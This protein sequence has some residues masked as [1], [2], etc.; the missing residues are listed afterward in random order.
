MGFWVLLRLPFWEGKEPREGKEPKEVKE[1]KESKEAQE[2]KEAN[3]A[4]EAKEAKDAR[5]RRRGE[6]E[7]EREAGQNM[8]GKDRTLCDA[9][10]FGL[11]LDCYS[12]NIIICVMLLKTWFW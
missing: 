9:M 6:R 2:A 5:G 4:R 7:R 8:R 12:N 10:A 11:L 3:E 1:A